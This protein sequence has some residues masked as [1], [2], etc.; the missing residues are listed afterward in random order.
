MTG[1]RREGGK[2][3]KRAGAGG[4][5]RGWPRFPARRCRAP[6]AGGVG[7]HTHLPDQTGKKTRFLRQEVPELERTENVFPPMMSQ[8]LPHT[9]HLL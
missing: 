6:S 1:A 5:W 4:G 7:N 8:M 2:P 3:G 9:L